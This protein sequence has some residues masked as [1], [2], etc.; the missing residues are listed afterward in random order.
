MARLTALRLLLVA[1]LLPQPALGGTSAPPRDLYFSEAIFWAE[2]GLYFDALQRLDTEITQYRGLDEPELDTL[3]PYVHDAEFFVGDFELSYRM[4]HRAGRAITAVL[5]GNVPEPVRNEA[6][7]RLARIHFQKGQLDDALRAIERID[8]QV[9]AGIRNDVEY[10]RANIYLATARPELAKPILRRLQGA[11]EL[12][13]FSEYNLAIAELQADRPEQALNQL[14]RAGS[15]KASDEPARAIRD[16]ANLV[17]GTMLLEA[18][19]YQEAKVALDRVRLEGPFSNQALLSAGWADTHDN[20]YQR[21]VVPWNILAKRNRTDPAVQEAMLALPYAYGELEVHGRAA[22]LY[23]RALESFGA[24][25]SRLDASIE[26]IRDG[27]FLEALIREEI[28][29]DRDWVIRLRELPDAPET[30]YLMTLM[31]SHDFQTGLS[32]YLDLEDLRKRLLR[33]QT[34]FEA[35]EDIISSRRA[36]YEPLL[37]Q[38][39]AQFREVDSRRRLRLQQHQLLSDRLQGLLVA[40]RPEFL[41]TTG[42]RTTSLQLA[43]LR[44]GL[45]EEADAVL[46]ERIDRLQ[47]LI[48]WQVKTDYHDRLTRFYEHL[49]DSQAAIDELTRQYDAYVRIRQAAAHSYVGYEIPIKRMRTRVQASLARIDLLMARQGRMLEQVAVRE[50]ESRVRRLEG[51]EERARYALADSYDRATAAQAALDRSNLDD[52]GAEGE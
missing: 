6:A 38:L 10:L 9:P 18:G 3:Y 23:N 32:N 45:D 48:T 44:A 34:S 22:V 52:G 37:P 26:A 20:R 5:E 15:V 49:E 42:E 31:A 47:G 50:L 17:R 29:K 27:R 25:L 39:D 24:E 4:H 16:K 33:W 35:F 12:A 8:G 51:Y 21:A 13:G 2:Q 40:P 46:I 36:Y 14:E 41:A 28:R 19:R 7:Y 11:K 43:S 30:F 1:F